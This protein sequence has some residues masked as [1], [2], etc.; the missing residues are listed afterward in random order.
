M[1]GVLIAA[2]GVKAL[3]RGNDRHSVRGRLLWREACV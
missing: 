3:C 2:L 1:D